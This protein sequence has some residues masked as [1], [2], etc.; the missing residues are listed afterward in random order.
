MTTF[1][2]IR[3]PESTIP[4]WASLQLAG[5]AGLLLGLLAVPAVGIAAAIGLVLFFVGA[6]LVHLRA[7]AYRSLPSPLFFL[8]LAVATLVLTVLR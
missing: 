4:L 2:D 5:A 6:S 3:L 8:A 1:G 7:H